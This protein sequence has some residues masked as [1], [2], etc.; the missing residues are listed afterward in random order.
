M[1]EGNEELYLTPTERRLREGNNTDYR[2]ILKNQI[3]NHE[4][5]YIPTVF[6]DLA[7]VAE[8]NATPDELRRYRTVG[9]GHQLKPGDPEYNQPIG[10]YMSPERAEELLEQ[11]LD[12]ALK[13]AESFFPGI[14]DAPENVQLALADMAYNLGGANLAQ[15]T[16]TKAFLEAGDWEGAAQEMMNSQW[17]D[18]VG[19]RADFLSAQVA[20]QID[21]GVLPG[22]PPA[23]RAIE[24][25][26]AFLEQGLQPVDPPAQQALEEQQALSN[27]L[28]A[29]DQEA[30][31]L[32][33]QAQREEILK[34][35]PDFA[36]LLGSRAV[37][38]DLMAYQMQLEAAQAQDELVRGAQQSALVLDPAAPTTEQIRQA[39]LNGTGPINFTDIGSFS[40]DM[41]A[42]A[43]D[44]Q[45]KSNQDAIKVNTNQRVNNIGNYQ[46]LVVDPA[47]QFQQQQIK[48]QQ[49]QL[50]LIEAEKAK[51]QT[52]K[53]TLPL[54]KERIDQELRKP[55]DTDTQSKVQKS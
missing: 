44:A 1:P 24:Q 37:E 5:G 12:Q 51:I 46:G 19:R 32:Q 14:D 18:Q 39:N 20:G 9:Y 43:M 29:Q 47:V 30:L 49:E 15:F 6:F 13:D 53:N 34:G 3:I 35:G 17:A 54:W 4:G 42:L 11:D 25:R 50:A 23:L 36:T 33:E 22:D 45:I 21:V 38:E 8:N 41:G 16:Q 48:E 27:A 40:S 28:A 26:K 52:L 10:S 2:S 31:F 7:G 55:R